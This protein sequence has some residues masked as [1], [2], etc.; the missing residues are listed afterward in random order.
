METRNEQN[1]NNAKTKVTKDVECLGKDASGKIK[2]CR[3]Q[4]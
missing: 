4:N 2:G 1:V 3:Y